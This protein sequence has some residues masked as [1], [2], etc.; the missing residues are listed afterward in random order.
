MT[1]HSDQSPA[2]NTAASHDVIDETIG[3]SLEALDDAHNYMRW[4]GDMVRPALGMRIL[5]VGAGHGTF[6]T[7]FAECGAVTALEPGARG[8]EVL[9]Q[10][11]ADDPRIQVVRGTVDDLPPAPTFDSAVMVNVLEHIDNQSGALQAIHQRLLPHGQIAIW[12]PAFEQ[13][14]SEFDRKLGHHRRYRK[15]ELEQLLRDHGYEIMSSR[16]VNLP[17]WFSWLILVRCLRLQPT[18][19]GFVRFWDRWIVP[20]VRAVESRVTPPFGQSILV[21]ARRVETTPSDG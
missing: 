17:G 19:R 2:A 13:L 12:V 8:F 9:E 6:S 15:P 1:N 10:R 18:S 14:F 3:S 11:F 7:T 21:I 5:E 4:I 16:Y 20:V